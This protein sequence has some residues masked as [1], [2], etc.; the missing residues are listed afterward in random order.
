MPQVNSSFFPPLSYSS[1]S[2]RS[3]SLNRSAGISFDLSETQKEFQNL[4]RDFAQNVVLPKAA[5][6]DHTMEFPVPLIEEAHKLGLMN[7]HIP[8]KY[9]GLGLGILDNCIIG[10][11][12]SYAC[13]GFGTV[14]N[15]NDLA[16]MPVIVAGNDEQKKKYLSRC[17]EAPI[18][19]SYCVTEPG[20]GS[21]VAGI[22]TNGTTCFQS[23]IFVHFL[24]IFS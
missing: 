13:A 7:T 16:Q 2:S 24:V 4:A 21:D 11:E 12:I 3:S 15:A 20:A 19:C 10:E 8:E 22:K 14:L 6:Y 17:V 1:F 23:P 5:H 18:Q 9:G